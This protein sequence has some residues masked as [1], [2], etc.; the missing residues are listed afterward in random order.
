MS[1]RRRSVLAVSL[2]LSACAFA[3][4]AGAEGSPITCVLVAR[5]VDG[6]AAQP[7]ADAVCAELA[8]K[9]AERGAYEVTVEARG[10]ALVVDHLA[11]HVGDRHGD[12]GRGAGAG[13]LGHGER[14]AHH[15]GLGASVDYRGVTPDALGV[16][17]REPDPTRP[18]ER[19]E[20]LAVLV[21]ARTRVP[22]E[23]KR[24]FRKRGGARVLPLEVLEGS[25]L[26][27]A[28]PLGCFPVELD[29]DLPLIA[30]VADDD[31]G[32]ACASLSISR[33]SLIEPTLLDLVMTR[34][35]LITP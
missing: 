20:A 12:R 9:G 2:A 22:F 3:P 10:G 33:P 30:R 8:V 35:R 25:S 26:A 5:G 27:E 34:V 1:H 19:R 32:S 17:A 28:T 18:G 15:A 31:G 21:P 7:V 14:V 23:G 11:H 16:R 29:A 6:A 13:H 4:R 24:V